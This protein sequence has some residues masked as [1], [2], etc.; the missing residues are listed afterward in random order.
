[1]EKVFHFDSPREHYRA[2]ACVLSCFDARFD[3]AIRKFLKRRGLA[4]YDQ[5]KIPGSAK[6]LA[7]PEHE[8]DRDFVLGM[9]RVSVSLHHAPLALLIGHNECGGYGGAPAEAIVADLARA[10]AVVRSALPSLD[11]ECYFAD[12]D[13]IY[14]CD[15]AQTG[16]MSA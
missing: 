8:G 13:G 4:V 14:R 5:V 10:A 11:V 2:D 6:A 12:F 3:T 1:M 15:S 9:L 16:T 7:A